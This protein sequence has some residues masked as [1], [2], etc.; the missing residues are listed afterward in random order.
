MDFL[1]LFM[2]LLCSFGQ[3]LICSHLDKQKKTIWSQ[4]AWMRSVLFIN[5]VWFL[6]RCLYPPISLYHYSSCEKYTV[7][8]PLDQ[9]LHCF[10]DFVVTQKLIKQTTELRRPV[11]WVGILFFFPSRCMRAVFFVLKREEM[12]PD[13]KGVETSFQ[14]YG[15]PDSTCQ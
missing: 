3:V 14:L 13:S 1:I 8:C 10:I 15:V 2:L 5:W 9:Y 6:F 7:S 12:V 11:D 4:K